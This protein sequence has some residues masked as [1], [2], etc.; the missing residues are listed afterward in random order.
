[1]KFSVA[2]EERV[3]LKRLKKKEKCYFASR[4][5][6]STD[7]DRGLI[8]AA[9]SRAEVRSALVALDRRL[10]LSEQYDADVTGKKSSPRRGEEEGRRRGVIRHSPP[11]LTPH[12]L[13]L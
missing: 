2:G 12:N 3:F 13:Q 11:L 8:T 6:L 10:V 4:L 1:M 7:R 9:S 5:G